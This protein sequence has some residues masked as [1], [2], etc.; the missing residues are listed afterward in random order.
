MT[1]DWN[2]SFVFNRV[3]HLYD[4]S[5]VITSQGF[6]KQPRALKQLLRQVDPEIEEEYEEIPLLISEIMPQTKRKKGK[7]RVKSQEEKDFAEHVSIQKQDVEFVGE[8]VKFGL[9]VAK[10]TYEYPE[11]CTT[12]EFHF[13]CFYHVFRNVCAIYLCLHF[14][15]M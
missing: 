13:L 3:T 2:G 14:C 10:T 1:S 7:K 8:M 9:N 6:A 15:L 5:R 12:V 11:L 4:F